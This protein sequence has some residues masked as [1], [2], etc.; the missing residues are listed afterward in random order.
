MRTKKVP[1]KQNTPANTLT[2]TQFLSSPKM[3]PLIGFVVNPP[4]DA[5]KNMIPVLKPISRSGEIC[6]TSGPISDTY[7]PLQKPNS[8][9]NA[10]MPPVLEL[11]IQSARTHMPVRAQTV[12]KMLYR[13]ILSPTIPENNRPKRLAALRI[14]SRYCTKLGSTP[15]SSAWTGR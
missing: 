1:A 13:P 10:M 15:A 12:T 11:G 7:A 5:I 4:M 6:A 2:P 3:A 9:A 14:D 8:A